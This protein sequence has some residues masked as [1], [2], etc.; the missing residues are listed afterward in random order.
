MTW[1]QRQLDTWDLLPTAWQ[2]RRVPA[3]QEKCC[4]ACS[5]RRALRPWPLTRGK[6]LGQQGA[7]GQWG[8]GEWG[9]GEDVSGAAGCTA[10]AGL[11]QRYSGGVI[12]L[13]NERETRRPWDVAETLNRCGAGF[14]EV[15]GRVLGCPFF[16]SCFLSEAGF[17]PWA[18]AWRGHASDSNR[19]RI[20]LSC[21]DTWKRMNSS[22]SSPSPCKNRCFPGCLFYSASSGQVLKAL[23]SEVAMQLGI[24]SFISLPFLDWQAL[25]STTA[26]WPEHL[27][28]HFG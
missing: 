17:L 13:Y 19:S 11:P 15:Q 21:M 9:K 28:A 8:A 22:P 27:R 14:S 3:V 26:C 1:H 24:K 5:R 6:K 25:F 18:C 4:C 2:S 23:G 12:P 7:R 20:H 16:S 10:S